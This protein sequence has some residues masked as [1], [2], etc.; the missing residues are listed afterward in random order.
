MPVINY[1]LDKYDVF[2]ST[3]SLKKKA[4]FPPK[5]ENKPEHNLK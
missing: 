5:T 3:S 4:I 1:K 2:W